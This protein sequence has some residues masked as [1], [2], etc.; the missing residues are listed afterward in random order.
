[1]KALMKQGK[2]NKFMPISAERA[3]S[4]QIS[5]D[6]MRTSMGTVEEVNRRKIDGLR[7]RDRMVCVG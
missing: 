1:M 5:V 7:W 2:R 6:T 4:R 3:G